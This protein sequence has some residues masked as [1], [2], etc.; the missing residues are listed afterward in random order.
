MLTTDPYSQYMD[1]QVKTTSP[2]KLLVTVHDAAIRFGRVAQEKMKQ[3]KLDEQSENIRK[4]QNILVELMA[5]LDPKVDRQLA[6]DLDALYTYM[7][8]RLTHA[9]IHDDEAALEEVIGIFSEL[10]A[11]WAEADIAAR[12][13]KTPSDARVARAA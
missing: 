7:F 5:S 12:S 2:G 6:A 1:V 10:R 8:D 11:T 9:N 13:G 4:M 3:H